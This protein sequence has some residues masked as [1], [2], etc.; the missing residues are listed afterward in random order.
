MP[1]SHLSKLTFEELGLTADV[2]RGVEDAGFTFCTPIQAKTLPIALKGKDVAGQAQTGTGKTAAF[3]LAAFDSSASP[4]LSAG[5]PF[6]RSALPDPG[7][8]PG[9]GYPD[10]QGRRT[11]RPEH[12]TSPWVWPTAARTTTSSATSLPPASIS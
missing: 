10:P 6:Q 8:D 12:R 7:A 5:A 2:A 1:D 11:A 3:L 4:P 9:A